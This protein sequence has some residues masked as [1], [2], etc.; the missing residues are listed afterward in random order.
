VQILFGKKLAAIE[1]PEFRERERLA[2]ETDYDARF[3]SPVEAAERG[4]VDEIIDPHETRRVL[5]AALAVHA[6]K[7]ETSVA[8][9]HSISPC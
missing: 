3:C 1:D 6:S 5:G 7:R 4:L 2:L 9:K 8:R